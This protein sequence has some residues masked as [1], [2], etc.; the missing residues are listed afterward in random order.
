MLEFL[1]I[2][3]ICA[4]IDTRSDIMEIFNTKILNNRQRWN[5]ALIYAIGATLISSVVCTVLQMFIIRSSLVYLAAA[6]FISWVI[7]ESG[8]GVQK[9]FSI[10]AAVCV[11][12]TIFLSEFLSVTLLGVN[13]VSAIYFVFTNLL[14]VNFNNLLSLL[15]K[16]Y[17]IYLAYMKARVL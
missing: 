16:A 9:K 3:I 6:Y 13:P 4:I 1:F 11:V 17:A 10:L 14:A 12:I 2:I 5:R 8:H 7:L 15:I